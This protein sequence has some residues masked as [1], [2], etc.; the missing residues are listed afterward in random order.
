MY[1]WP[2]P[3]HASHVCRTKTKVIGLTYLFWGGEREGGGACYGWDTINLQLSNFIFYYSTLFFLYQI[4]WSA[5]RKC[6]KGQ[7]DNIVDIKSILGIL[8]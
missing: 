2:L 1:V 5:P 4:N 3:L 6:S 8:F 7:Y